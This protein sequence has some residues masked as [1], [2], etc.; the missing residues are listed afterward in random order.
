MFSSP[1]DNPHGQPAGDIAAREERPASGI[2]F[3]AAQPETWRRETNQTGP[4]DASAGEP[5]E[6]ER[7]HVTL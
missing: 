5:T 6:A 1:S 2:R 4:L 7:L 3:R